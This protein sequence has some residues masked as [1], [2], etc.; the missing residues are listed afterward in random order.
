MKSSGIYYSNNDGN[1]PDTNILLVSN[2]VTEWVSNLI[3]IVSH[4]KAAIVIVEV[5]PRWLSVLAYLVFTVYTVYY[6][7]GNI[8]INIF[9]QRFLLGH[10][11]LVV[12]IVKGDKNGTGH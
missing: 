9:S 5:C 3:P 10:P 8:H 11:F 2:S 12:L 7:G 4:Q 6:G 1:D